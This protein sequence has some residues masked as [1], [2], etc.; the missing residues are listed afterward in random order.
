MNARNEIIIYLLGQTSQ[1]DTLD[2]AHWPYDGRVGMCWCSASGP[3]WARRAERCAQR[4]FTL[5]CAVTSSSPSR[6]PCVL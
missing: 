6:L 4:G 5:T 2:T 3:A 1:T